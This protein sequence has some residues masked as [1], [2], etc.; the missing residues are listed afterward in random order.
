MGF[1]LTRPGLFRSVFYFLLLYALF[2]WRAYATAG[3]E[4][5]VWQKAALFG[6][7]ILNAFYVTRILSQNLIY[8]ERTYVPALVY[9]LA[10]MGYT[11]TGLTLTTSA[12]AFLLIFA[13]DNMIRSYKKESDPGH[14]L[15][16]SIALGAAPLLYAPAAIFVWLLPAGLILFKQGGRSVATAILGYLLPVF[17]LSYIRWGMGGDFL[18]TVR[19]IFAQLA[20][21]VSGAGIW[22]TMTVW[23]KVLAG[24]FLFLTLAGGF[25]FVRR[26]SGVRRRAVRGYVLF[27]WMALFCAVLVALPG[28]G[29]E[30]LPIAA[31]PMAAII[32]ACFNRRA[33]WWPNLL[34]TVMM[35]SVVVYNLR[36]LL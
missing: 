10:A 8:L 35:M 25:G 14:F 29:L 34:Y 19:H 21:A 5:M 23:D 1:D 6:L 3:E 22:D 18:D 16:A 11:T 20:P 12:V 17:F 31:V 32:P 9:A 13:L 28:R 27:V 4:I 15:N 7:S 33:G 26:R 36:F 2:R 30:L 24:I